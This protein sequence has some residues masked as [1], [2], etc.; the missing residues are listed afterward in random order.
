MSQ[1]RMHRLEGRKRTLFLSQSQAR[2]EKYRLWSG[3]EVV[4]VVVVVIFGEET[5]ALD[6]RVRE[7]LLEQGWRV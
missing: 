5:F 7:D 6:V 2:R 1:P 3:A 4:V